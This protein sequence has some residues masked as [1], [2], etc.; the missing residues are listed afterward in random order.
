MG[1]E[2]VYRYAPHPIIPIINTLI[3]VD[4]PT[5]AGTGREIFSSIQK[6]TDIWDSG[7][8]IHSKV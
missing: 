6:G 8:I 7:R 4:G 3:C 5:G 1:K 2:A